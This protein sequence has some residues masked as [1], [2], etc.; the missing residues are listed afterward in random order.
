MISKQ[1]IE[2]I[3]ADWCKALRFVAIIEPDCKRL[4]PLPLTRVRLLSRNLSK[5]QSS[6]RKK[7]EMLLT[8]QPLGL[9][10]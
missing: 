1:V 6:I 9:P 4:R 8:H 7:F 10:C 5:S 3:S 2:E